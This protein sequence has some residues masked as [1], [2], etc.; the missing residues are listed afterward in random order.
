VNILNENTDTLNKNT[1]AVLEARRE[2][3]VEVN[4]EKTRYMVVSRHQNVG[5]S[6]NLQIANKSHEN[7]EKFKS[8]RAAVTNK[9]YIHEEIK[10]R[11]NSGNACYHSV[12][13]LLSS[14]L[15]Y[16]NL[17]VKIHETIILPVVLYWCETLSL[18]VRE[19]V[20][21]LRVYGNRV[22]RRIEN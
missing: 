5:Q 21:S 15:S 20:H 22:L 8:L 17:N 13:S 14:H 19:E 1:E 7:V 9:N 16:E 6:H 10:S 11:L 12:Q 2:D 3:G 18:A 4:T